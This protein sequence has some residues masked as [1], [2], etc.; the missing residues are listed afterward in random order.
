[1][2]EEADACDRPR[3]YVT[4]TTSPHTCL[5]K[6]VFQIFGRGEGDWL[7]PQSFLHKEKS[8]ADDTID[9]IKKGDLFFVQSII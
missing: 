9:P 1:M 8:L 4:P 6:S 7:S 5:G 3:A 2:E